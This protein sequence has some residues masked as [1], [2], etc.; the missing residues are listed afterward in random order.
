[1]QK[2][3]DF[4]RAYVECALWSS[5]DNSSC[6]EAREG[7]GEPLD[8]D[9]SI[10]DIEPGTMAELV[11]DCAEFQKRHADLLAVAYDLYRRRE[12]YT[13]QSRAGH[14]FWLTR[15]G[16]GCGFW[17]RQELETDGIG[18]KLTE[19]AEAFGEYTLDV[20]EENPQTVIGY[21]G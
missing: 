15:N 4:T 5:T 17:D 16:H 2:L 3:D 13:P 6:E 11:A 14:D 18:D 20:S 21:K 8:K 9:H 19:A 10:D 7:Q 1:M 12:D